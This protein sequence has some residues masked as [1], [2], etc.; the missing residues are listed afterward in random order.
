MEGTLL[1]L[2][3]LPIWIWAMQYRGAD[4]K[5]VAPSARRQQVITVVLGVMVI[6][7]VL[8]RHYGVG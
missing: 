5:P 3:Q 4:G 6:T 1:L 2:I 8:R 7:L